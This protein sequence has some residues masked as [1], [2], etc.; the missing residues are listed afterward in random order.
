MKKTF[1]L[2]FSLLSL[3][4]S[5]QY[6]SPFFATMPNDL[7]P[8]LSQNNRKDLI[9]LYKSGKTP[10]VENLLKETTQLK[11]L[12]EDFISLQLSESSS[13]E[14][15]LLPISD[16]TK[17]IALI[18]TVCGK[19]CDSRIA[20]YTTSWKSINSSTILPTVSVSDFIK[21]PTNEDLLRAMDV[22]FFVYSFDAENQ[23]LTVS[24]DA[25]NWLNKA[26]FDKFSPDLRSSIVLKW[27]NGKFV[28]E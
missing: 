21:N 13:A 8:Y 16:T 23:Q 6:I 12:K 3:T 4:A 27:S 14:L 25:K 15:K 24:L 26:D 1:I 20:F 28:K 17:I 10:K 7:L 19:A 22:P 5:A 18:K 9:D 2:L 11:A